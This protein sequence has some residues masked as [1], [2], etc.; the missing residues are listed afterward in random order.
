MA[1][2]HPD[3]ASRYVA[4]QEE[5]AEALQCLAPQNGGLGCDEYMVDYEGKLTPYHQVANIV[6]KLIDELKLVPGRDVF[7]TP[8]I[9]SAEKE[10]IFR[11]YASILAAVE[12]NY[13]TR[14]V[15][16]SVIEVVH[17]MTSTGSELVEV[18]RRIMAMEGIAKTTGFPQRAIELIPLVEEVPPQLQ[19]RRMLSEYV[20]G[21]EK[22]LGMRIP[23]LRV[24]VGK[25]DSALMYGHVASVI[26]CKIAIADVYAFGIENEIPVAPIFG[27]GAL[28]FRGHITVE[29][30]YNVLHEY[31]GTRTITVQSGIRYDHGPEKAKQLVQILRR[32]LPKGTPLSYT[33]EQRQR[34]LFICGLFAKHYIKTLLN[35]APAVRQL[36]DILP[37]QR[38]RLVRA[39]KTGYGRW[40]PRPLE[41]AE[42]CKSLAEGTELA[43]ELA[44]LWAGDLELPRAITYTGS[45]YTICLPPEFIGTGRGLLELSQK[46]EG[47]FEALL[48][49]YYPS[50]LADLKFA[51]RFLDIEKVG[52]FLPKEA[53]RE[54]TQDIDLI[55]ELLGL[56]LEPDSNY[57]SMVSI[58]EPYL[59][60]MRGKVEALPMIDLA[61]LDPLARDLFSKLGKIRGSLG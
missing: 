44:E 22:E 28:P 23:Y 32:E 46:D 21:C 42:L 25:S 9:A 36:S 1:T 45:L 33:E 19:I 16:P 14:E 27:G 24:F 35:I 52:H 58:V 60:I 38:D 50:L 4:V 15:G 11:Q 5:E 61:K 55:R 40:G 37:Q 39:G 18:R 2:Q 10:T 34:M 12:A 8:R 49:E 26:S 29:N 56:E 53:I 3:S 54:V 31:S 41:L 6:V 59:N 47:S 43:R 7:I 20:R 57:S 30:I 51:G 48:K 17:P 13:R